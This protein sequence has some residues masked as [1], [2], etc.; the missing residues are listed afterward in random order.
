[1]FVQSFGKGYEYGE[2][3]D[4]KDW[5]VP[6]EANPGSGLKAYVKVSNGV[7]DYKQ[8][9]DNGAILHSGTGYESIVNKEGFVRIFDYNKGGGTGFVSKVDENGGILEIT[10]DGGRII[11]T[12]I[13]THP[14]F[15]S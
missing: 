6:V 15:I 1:M 12:W 4:T 2:S 8:T 13:K 5:I 10:V 11:M 7:L 3:E 14:S 9:V